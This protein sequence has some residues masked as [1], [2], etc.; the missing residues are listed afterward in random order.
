MAENGNGQKPGGADGELFEVMQWVDP[1]SLKFTPSTRQKY[2]R[3]VVRKQVVA[4]KF[5][6]KHWYQSA[7]AG[8]DVFKKEPI[9]PAELR[10][11][12]R[13]AGFKAWFYDEFPEAE[14]ISEEELRFLDQQ[15][16]SGVNDGMSDGQKWA[17]E[18][19]AKIRFISRKSEQDNSEV[20][21]LEEYF[22]AGDSAKWRVP[23]AEA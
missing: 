19:Y 6:R 11:W 21:E 7:N 15:W 18:V 23:A 22:R 12:L 13:S 9:G 14:P 20:K 17:Y 4:G 8:S 5:F 1:E 2:F 3:N 16:W 10:K